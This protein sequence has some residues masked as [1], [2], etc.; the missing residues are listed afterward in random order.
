MLYS[1]SLLFIYFIHISMFS[2]CP[3]RETF[4]SSGTPSIPYPLLDY[5]P[6]T[7]LPS[8]PPVFF[9]LSF[10]LPISRA[11]LSWEKTGFSFSPRCQPT[12]G[13]VSWSANQPI[14]L[15]SW[16]STWDL[17]SAGAS[18]FIVFCRVQ[19]G[20]TH[21]NRVVLLSV[22]LLVMVT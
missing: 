15:H 9:F 5:C 22:S 21:L 1:R 4:A 11:V 10:S 6:S 3:F 12:R 13:P 17:H 7:F 14:M 8:L 16:G 18:E 20:N 19:D 2:L